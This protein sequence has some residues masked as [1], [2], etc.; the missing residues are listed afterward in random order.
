VVLLSY[1]PRVKNRKESVFMLGIWEKNGRTEEDFQ[2]VLSSVVFMVDDEPVLPAVIWAGLL[3]GVEEKTGYPK[4]PSVE[5]EKVYR[6]LVDLYV[7]DGSCTLAT[8]A[9]ANGF[10]A[11]ILFYML[12]RPQFSSFLECVRFMVSLYQTE[13]CFTL[14]AMRGF[15][16]EDAPS[17]AVLPTHVLGLMMRDAYPGCFQQPRIMGKDVFGRVLQMGDVVYTP[18]SGI[19]VVDDL[20]DAWVTIVSLRDTGGQV[21]QLSPDDV[22]RL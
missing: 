2:G 5:R 15:P 18:Q 22:L 13:V 12:L 11:F 9:G 17:L 6:M 10:T 16:F 1:T 19:S 21:F 14:G 3:C 7:T 8:M 20:N 4:V